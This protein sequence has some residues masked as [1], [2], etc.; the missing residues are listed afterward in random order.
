MLIS[1]IR[2]KHLQKSITLSIPVCYTMSHIKMPVKMSFLQ[3]RKVFFFLINL[4]SQFFWI[5]KCFDYYYLDLVPYIKEFAKYKA[6]HFLSEIKKSH[7]K[8]GSIPI[9]VSNTPHCG[10]E[11]AQQKNHSHPRN[12]FAKCKDCT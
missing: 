8:K 11:S 10:S 1:L 4:S 12:G 2:R 5:Q 6:R 7:K 3:Y 9:R